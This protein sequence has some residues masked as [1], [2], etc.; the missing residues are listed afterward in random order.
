[1]NAIPDVLQKI[2]DRKQIEITDRSQ[3]T[4]LEML[5]E[6]AADAT[7]VRGFSNALLTTAA[8]GQ[9][10]VICRNKKSIA[11]QGRVARGFS[12][13]CNCQKL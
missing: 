8:S 9:S 5:L 7:S 3:H 10:A 1:M 11:K 2:I 6:R 13:G 4:P 12:S